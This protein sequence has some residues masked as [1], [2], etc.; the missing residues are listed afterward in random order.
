MGGTLCSTPI[1]NPAGYLPGIISGA[2]RGDAGR[3][4][5]LGR[6]SRVLGNIVG[7]RQPRR[8]HH[9][10]TSTAPTAVQ[11]QLTQLRSI[12]RIR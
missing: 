6:Y 10:I 12:Q 9:N 11:H 1:C 7:C 4:Q 8:H 5:R 3:A 2:M